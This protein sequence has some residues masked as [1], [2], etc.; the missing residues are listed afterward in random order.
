M[1]KDSET[2]HTFI[3]GP[4]RLPSVTMNT[5]ICRTINRR[6]KSDTASHAVRPS[7]TT[8]NSRPAGINSPEPT[9]ITCR[10]LDEALSGPRGGTKCRLYKRTRR[11][12]LVEFM[13]TVNCDTMGR[14][15]LHGDVTN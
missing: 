1:N 3:R 8:I 14:P 6:D 10:A 4:I 11:S 2:A 5:G 15:A 12:A 9:L 13:S 7:A